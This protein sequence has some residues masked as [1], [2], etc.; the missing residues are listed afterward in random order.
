MKRRLARLFS[1]QMP[2][3]RREF[4]V[5]TSLKCNFVLYLLPQT[6]RQVPDQKFA[7][8]KFLRQNGKQNEMKMSGRLKYRNTNDCHREKMLLY[9]QWPGKNQRKGHEIARIT[10][11]L[12]SS[13]NNRTTSVIHREHVIYLFDCCAD[14]IFNSYSNNC[15]LTLR[16]GVRSRV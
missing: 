3:N 8:A 10:E 2:Q 9:V 5:E 4:L 11:W 6:S 7:T 12:Y 13:K 14:I 1:I 15:S 16:V